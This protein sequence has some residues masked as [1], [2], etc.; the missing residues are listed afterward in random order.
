MRFD[1]F[2][3]DVILLE[4]NEFV[5]IIVKTTFDTPFKNEKLIRSISDIL[6]KYLINEG[7]INDWVEIRS[8]IVDIKGRKLIPV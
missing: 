6:V 7:F 8:R 5:E 3:Y 1:V 4:T 2:G